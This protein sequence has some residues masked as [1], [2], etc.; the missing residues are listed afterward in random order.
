[1]DDATSV[2]SY[3]LQDDM[4]NQ[5]CI[6]IIFR[7]VELYYYVRTHLVVYIFIRSCFVVNF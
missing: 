4:D 1:M 6:H 3:L 2:R 7:E 5:G